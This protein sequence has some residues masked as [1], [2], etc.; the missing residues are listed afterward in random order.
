MDDDNVPEF[1]EVVVGQDGFRKRVCNIIAGI[2]IIMN[3]LI[4]LQKKDPILLTLTTPSSLDL[5][6]TFLTDD[7]ED[8][9]FLPAK[10]FMEELWSRIIAVDEFS[11]DP[12][13]KSEQPFWNTYR[14]REDDWYKCSLARTFTVHFIHVCIYSRM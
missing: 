1:E 6:D 2:I 11:V 5:A 9:R 13:R 7:F 12:T 3:L 14:G 8:E 10:K 4:I